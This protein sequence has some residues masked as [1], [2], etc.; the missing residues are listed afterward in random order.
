MPMKLRE[1]WRKMVEADWSD[2]KTYP[3]HLWLSA[4]WNQEI[5]IIDINDNML[6]VKVLAI[7]LLSLLSLVTTDEHDHIVSKKIFA[8]GNEII[9]SNMI[10]FMSKLRTTL[11]TKKA[12]LYVLQNSQRMSC[13]PDLV[14]TWFMINE[15]MEMS[16]WHWVQLQERKKE[17]QLEV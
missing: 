5:F 9:A 10:F 3:S 1:N 15:W 14:F 16:E 6:S 4:G 2:T 17:Y 7:L 8:S 12:L 13:L 11:K